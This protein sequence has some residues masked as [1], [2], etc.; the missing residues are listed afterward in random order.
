MKSGP[1]HTAERGKPSSWPPVRERGAVRMP[2]GVKKKKK[3]PVPCR[4]IQLHKKG[5]KKETVLSHTRLRGKREKGG[6]DA[7]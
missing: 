7:D 5:K 3:R 6:G 4:Y 2:K 1:V